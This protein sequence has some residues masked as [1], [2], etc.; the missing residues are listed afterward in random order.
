MPQSQ[1]Q[2]PRPTSRTPS[3]PPVDTV[4]KVNTKISSTR[5]H[6][7][8]LGRGINVTDP[9]MW[10][11]KSS[12]LVREVSLSPTNIIITDECGRKEA[13]CKEVSSFETQRQ[14]IQ[15]TL[16]DPVS[17]VKLGMDAQHSQSTSS[18]MSITGTKYETKT[19]PFKSDFNSVPLYTSVS[20]VSLSLPP[21][22]RSSDNSFEHTFCSWILNAFEIRLTRRKRKQVMC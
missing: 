4:D 15:L 14:Q 2:V 12:F 11:N 3:L 8:G 20:N 19:V 7:L 21:D 17:Q 10:K 18:S 16:D 1:H 6:E 22:V 9:E 5:Y 13:Y